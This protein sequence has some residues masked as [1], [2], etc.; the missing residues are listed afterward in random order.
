VGNWNTEITNVLYVPDATANILSVSSTVKRGYC[1]FFSN[2]GCRV[3]DKKGCKVI[4]RQVAT[5][6]EVKGVYELEVD[7]PQHDQQKCFL[8]ENT[9]PYK[10]IHNGQELRHRRSAHLNTG[11]MLKLKQKN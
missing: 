8:T 11:D 7:S 5:A 10:N 3:F 2:D 6:K 1:M 9:H 4:G